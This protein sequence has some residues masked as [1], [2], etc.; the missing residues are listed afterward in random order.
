MITKPLLN[1]KSRVWFY[2]HW[3]NKAQNPGCGFLTIGL[4]QPKILGVVYRWNFGGQNLVQHLFKV[5]QA[6]PVKAPVLS[7]IIGLKY[8]KHIVVEKGAIHFA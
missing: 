6:R 8:C 2:N 7:V 3:F 4:I 1:P 5:R